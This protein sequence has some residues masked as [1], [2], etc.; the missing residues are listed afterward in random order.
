M[1]NPWQRAAAFTIDLF[2]FIILGLASLIFFDASAMIIY[3]T[4]FGYWLYDL[5][6]EY[7]LNGQTFGK[8]ILKIQVRKLDGSEPSFINY[9]L[10]WLLRPI[11]MQL[12]FMVQ[13]FAVII[14]K[15]SQRIGDLTAS[16]S[17]FSLKKN[18]TFINKNRRFKID[19]NYIVTYEGA[20]YLSEK[21]IETIKETLEF[22]RSVSSNK[23]IVL[24]KKATEAI[25]KKIG[26]NSSQAPLDFLKTI[27]KDYTH[28]Y[29]LKAMEKLE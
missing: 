22:H 11:D 23:S 24:L 10:R 8:S 18:N 1:A 14:S 28:I 12:F 20:E 6:M 21:D 25:E 9:F 29:T 16:T 26:E 3:I 17:V 5:L 13:F 19:K 2:I 7:F 4:L 15:N 27:I